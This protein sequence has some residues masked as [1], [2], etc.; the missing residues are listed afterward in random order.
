MK[1]FSHPILKVAAFWLLISI[2]FFS[3][4]KGYNAVT[5]PVAAVPVVTNVQPKSPLPGDVVT[6]SGA[7]FGATLT[8]VKVTIGTQVIAISTVTDTEIKFTLPIGLTAGDIAVAIK[9]IIA[10]NTDPQKATITPQI[11]TPAVA[12]IVAIN[13]TSG[14][15][16]DVVSITGTNF[17]LTPANNV[18]KFNGIAAT[19]TGSVGTVLT[20]TVPT[21]ATTGPV[22]LSV[23]GGTVITG[24]TFTV[25]ASTGGTGNTVPYII[26]VGGTATFTKIAT[27]PNDIYAMATDKKNNILYYSTFDA[28]H[29]GTVYKLKLDGSAP[30]VLSSD[31]RINTIYII[32]TDAAGNVYVEAGLDSQG[33]KNNIYKIDPA[34]GAVTVIASNVTFG[35]QSRVFTVDSQGGIWLGYNT[36]LNTTTN[37]F[38]GNGSSY[39]SV[40]PAFYKDDIMYVEDTYHL[41]NGSIGF[42]KYNL[43]TQTGTATDFTLQ[44]LFKQDDPG[45][46]AGNT[47]NSSRY[48]MD[49][50]HISLWR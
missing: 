33:L 16:G 20:L 24:P 32:T 22:T 5:P 2:V 10:N 35:G 13:P 45:I 3:C 12:T 26:A 31:V 21:G 42:H 50:S 11:P 6:I 36:K 4:K 7:G 25:N 1:N 18:V 23:N 34:S 15:V 14:K 27:A 19:V 44:S 30:V 49:N 40:A 9:G 37:T 28:N 47:Q 38:V 39:T 48:T 46:V 17:N 8:D 29:T 41:V 43:L